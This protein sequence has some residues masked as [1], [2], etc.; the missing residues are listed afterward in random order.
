MSFFE[1]LSSYWKNSKNLKSLLDLENEITDKY[2]I[3]DNYIAND[4]N[5]GDLY[6]F[7]SHDTIKK[8]KKILNLIHNKYTIN[9]IFPN[10]STRI[11]CNK[12]FVEN[13]PFVT[14]LMSGDWGDKNIFT[15]EYYDINNKVEGAINIVL[16]DTVMESILFKDPYK[17][18]M[19]DF[20][21]LNS[22]HNQLEIANI[23]LN[24]L[25]QSIIYFNKLKFNHKLSKQLYEVNS[26]TE[27]DY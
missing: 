8:D 9:L 18:N 5:Y 13:L 4:F 12:K 14:R 1:D 10:Y 7:Y 11:I 2:A 22:N 3:I 19:V 15:S 25:L 6:E 23:E 16:E 17:Y 24:N 20:T 27:Y 26:T 21:N